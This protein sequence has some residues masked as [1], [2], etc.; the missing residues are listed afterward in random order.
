MNRRFIT[1]ATLIASLHFSSWLGASGFLTATGFK[2]WRFHHFLGAV[3]SHGESP[4]Q[5]FVFTVQSVLCYPAALLP[6]LSGAE[7]GLEVLI[8]IGNSLVW[9][10]LVALAIGLRGRKAVV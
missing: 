7:P 5:G 6:G 3:P 1:T 2:L 9:G 4:L 10:F 8:L